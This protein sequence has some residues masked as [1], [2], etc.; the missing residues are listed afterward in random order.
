MT[1]RLRSLSNRCEQQEET[2][3]IRIYERTPRTNRSVPIPA[4]Y[5]IDFLHLCFPILETSFDSQIFR[6]FWGHRTHGLE[7]VRAKVQISDGVKS[8]RI[9]IVRH[10]STRYKCILEFNPAR[11]VDPFGVG[12]CRPQDLRKVLRRVMRRVAPYITACGKIEDFEV[13]RVDVARNLYGVFDS[14]PYFYGLLTVPKSHA[15]FS[16]LMCSPQ[17]GRPETYE[18]GSQSGEKL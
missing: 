5:G 1:L 3:Q 15:T 17:T 13:R 7:V 8:I 9:V 6:V 11:F 2:E 16:R 18:A 14:A 10:E 4:D 12:L